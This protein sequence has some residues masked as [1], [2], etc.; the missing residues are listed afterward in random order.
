MDRT[1]RLLLVSLTAM[2]GGRGKFGTPDTSRQPKPP[3]NEA[4]V[5][6]KR[7]KRIERGKRQ[8]ERWLQSGGRP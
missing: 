5:A 1:A 8:Y 3:R 7:A 2:L 6:A 4:Q